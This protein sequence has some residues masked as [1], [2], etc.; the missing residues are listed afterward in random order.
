MKISEILQ[1][2]SVTVSCEL[3]PPKQGSQLPQVE[4]V[5]ADMAEY[6]PTFMSVTYGAGGT[7]VGETI[8]I[9]QTI[10]DRHQIPAL[11]HLTCLTATREQIDRTLNELQEKGI[12]NLLALRGDIPAGSDF[13][14]PEQFHHASDLIS[15]IR[16]GPW[17]FCI[18]A[19]CNPEG[20]PESPSRE[21]DIRR[22]K[23]KV[24]CGCSF[25]TTQMF[26]DNNILYRFLYQVREAGI[27]IPV[28][29]GIMPVTNAKQVD[30]M[31]EMNRIEFPPR[32]RAIVDHFGSDSRAMRQ[33]GIAYATEQI[34]DLIANGVKHIHIYTMNQ[35][36][37]AGMIM[38][39]LS[40]IFK[41]QG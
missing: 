25:I 15:Y 26:F 27:G 3:F 33:A 6:H 16:S 30:R 14:N 8:S 23:E 4:Q 5:V 36:R 9:A 35:P 7:T 37:T 12:Q 38:K 21:E 22:L 18:G 2:N 24:D 41:V 32:F 17:D 11:A 1:K 31:I 28:I 40:Q 10:Q 29:A 19:A 34:I 13:P 20:H 39:N